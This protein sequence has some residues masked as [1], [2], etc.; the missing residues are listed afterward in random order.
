MTLLER[1]QIGCSV[2]AARNTEKIRIDRTVPSRTVVDRSLVS[3]A[4]HCAKRFSPGITQTLVCLLALVFSVTGCTGVSQ[5]PSRIGNLPNGN[6]IQTHARPPLHGYWNDFDPHAKSLT[7]TPRSAINQ[8]GTHHVIV[9]SVCDD[10]GSGRRSRRV[11]WH[12]SGVGYIVE[13]DESGLF[14]GRGYLVDDKYAVSYTN[15]RPHTLTRGSKDTRDDVALRPGQ[16]Y[17]VIFSPEEG[18]THVTCYAPGINDWQ[19]HKVTVTKHWVDAQP[20]FPPPAINRAGEP[21]T[22]T[23]RVVRTSDGSGHNG[24][25]V[26]Y[27]VLSGPPAVFAGV[28]TPAVEVM[29]DGAGQGSAI[30]QQVQAI[31]GTNQIQIDVVRPSDS[32][33]G[34]ELLISSH[35]TTKTWVAPQISMQKVAPQAVAVGSQIPYK[36]IVTNTGSVATSGLTI[37]DTIPPT[38]NLIGSNPPA[39]IQ[40]SNLLWNFG[41]LQPNQ[42]VAVDFACQATQAGDINNCAEAATPDGLRQESCS[43]T[44]VV[45]GNLVVTKA[46]PPSALVGQPITFQISVTNNG[47]APVL[48][49][50]LVDIFDA[51]L[52]SDQGTSPLSLPVGTIGPGETKVVP[53]TLVAQAP[54]RF[55]NH[56]TAEGDGVPAAVAEHCVEV[57]QPQVQIIKKGPPGAIVGANV[58]FQIA[59]KNTGNIAAQNVVIQDLLPS[60]LQPVSVT[61][62]G[63]VQ[64]QSAIWNLGTMAPGEEKQVGVLARALA[65]GAN[66]CNSATVTAV[67]I[68]TQQSNPTCL[69]IQGVPGLLT[70]M[71]DRADP[72]PIGA[73]T[74]YTI[75]LTNQGSEPITNLLLE[76]E[77]PPELKFVDAE[78][79][80]STLPPTYKDGAEAGFLYFKP[81]N[82]G[83]GEPGMLPGKRIIYQ[84]RAK[85]VRPGDARFAIRITS[86]QIKK[87]IVNMESTHCF[88]PAT[89]ATTSQLLQIPGNQILPAGT[90]IP[91][92]DDTLIKPEEA[93]SDLTPAKGEEVSPKS[94]S[95]SVTKEPAAEPKIDLPPDLVLPE[96]EP[97]K[98]SQAGPPMDADRPKT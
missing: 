27:R 43:Q 12:V 75:Q 59:V 67:G 11:E 68:P 84:V 47:Q 16:T 9:A 25:R 58:E 28:N 41:P 50:R 13:V 35:V 89:G 22:L 66:I 37:R 94:V 70:E 85:A 3:S 34:R 65:G 92:P 48:N 56:V 7:V 53:I 54:G 45:A 88:D 42:S 91:V 78:G 57:A 39:S 14:P 72:V 60:Q 33:T 30:L 6:I 31:P 71:I 87:P 15:F 97:A 19:K 36:I 46:G 20:I 64:G 8:V 74:V 77:L 93:P 96:P 5:N 29:T 76:C 24:Y 4:W 49:T 55:C 51:G 82:G 17:C 32:P 40:G 73:D 81:F 61:G 79:H 2:N 63:A 38:L 52:A 95:I 98:P 44:K 1:F 80:P 18:E 86:D 10:E 90:T 69:N 62:P 26:R 21:H 23:T 83:A